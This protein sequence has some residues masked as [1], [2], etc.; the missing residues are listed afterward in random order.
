MG[1]IFCKSY[2]DLFFF[3]H[4]WINFFYKTVFDNYYLVQYLQFSYFDWFAK[5]M[6]TQISYTLLFDLVKIWYI[7]NF[8]VIGCPTMLSTRI[9]SLHWIFQFVRYGD[10]RFRFKP[11]FCVNFNRQFV[12]RLVLQML[13]TIMFFVNV[14]SYST[15]SKY[16]TVLIE[17]LIRKKSVS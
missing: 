10:G 16:P 6:Q 14:W 11:F 15:S 3:I 7:Q 17:L 5:I 8:M 12:K 1:K 2:F 9:V 13:G 4:I